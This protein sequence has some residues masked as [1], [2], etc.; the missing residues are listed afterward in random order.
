MHIQSRHSSSEEYSQKD[1]ENDV[2]SPTASKYKKRIISLNQKQIFS[3]YGIRLYCE[4]ISGKR[5]VRN[6]F[7]FV[8]I[9][10]FSLIGFYLRPTIP[11]SMNVPI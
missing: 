8:C 5:V 11:K 7:I 2:S 1:V 9:F 6:T 4:R 3:Q 10:I